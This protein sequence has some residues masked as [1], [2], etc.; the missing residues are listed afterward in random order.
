MRRGIQISL[1]VLGAVAARGDVLTESSTCTI[2]GTSVTTPGSCSQNASGYSASVQLMAAPGSLG[3]SGSVMVS[4]LEIPPNAGGSSAQGSL[5]YSAELYTPGPMRPGFLFP[6]ANGSGGGDFFGSGSGSAFIG[7]WCL[8]A[9]STAGIQG[10]CLGPV[11]IPVELGTEF[12]F[13]VMMGASAS[14]SPING[15]DNGFVVLDVG[16]EFVEA[17]G[18]T[19]VAALDSP[20]PSAGL[21]CCVGL[22]LI[23]A[24]RKVR[25]NGKKTCHAETRKM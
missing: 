15:S 13:S 5:S 3:F 10:N 8:F 12:V 1:I 19:P 17:D 9:T 20:E 16:F 22:G 2:F 6:S 21:L 25:A 11:L 24:I 4:V 23:G 18:V 7:P 14:S